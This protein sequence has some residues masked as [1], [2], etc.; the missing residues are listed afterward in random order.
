M[1]NDLVGYILRVCGVLNK[2][3]IEYMIV[4]GVAVALHGYFRKSI[5]PDGKPVDKPDMDIWYNPTYDNYFRL[6][7]ALQELGQ[8]VEQFKQ[9]QAPEPNRS[10]FKYDLEDFTLDFLPVLSAK[11]PF[12]P[13]F[14]KKELV[15]L[16]N[17]DIPFIG[18]EDLISDKK[19]MRARKIW[20]ILNT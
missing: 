11:T 19:Q 7:D 13:S 3:A 8:D 5:G 14:K 18:F 4:G 15:S 10:F 9:E 20:K 1:E 17:I 2:H 16:N 12:G 6:L